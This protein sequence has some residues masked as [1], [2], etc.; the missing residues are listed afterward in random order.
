MKIT[1]LS[2]AYPYRG[3]I[4]HFTGL[5]YKELIKEHEVNVITF[6]RQYP[7][8]LFPGSTQKE[9]ENDKVQKIPTEQIV[10]SINPINW[11]TSGIRI[12]SIKPDL[13]IINFWLPFFG[14]SF[15]TISKIVK[16]NKKTKIVT[17][18]H[19]II[20]HERK[21]GDRLFTK[22]F[23]KS[24]DSF[25]LLAK[26]LE[27]DLKILKI[28]ARYK[29]LYH[30]VYS[31]FGEGIKK[32]EARELLKVEGEKVILFFG[33]IREYK[34]LDTLLEAFALIKDK[35]NLKLI[36]AGEFY[37]DEALYQELI[38]KLKIRENIYLFTRF[39]PS[40]EVRYYFSAADVVVLPYKNATQSGI[41][42][43]ANNF[44]KPVIATDVGGLGEV[45]FENKTGFLVVKENPGK[46]ADAILKYFNE[47]KEEEFANNI[48]QEEDKFSWNNFVK[49]L[50][51]AVK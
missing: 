12:N 26:K 23:F 4:A 42:Q 25:V 7:G 49:G 9:P 1:I 47:N 20:P 33:F 2:A 17:I 37:S 30:P 36:I 43:I 38:D 5:L 51:E 18:C 14:P 34:G 44:N 6:K 8:F 29:T 21:P 39:I 35:L 48:K 19:N 11:I 45:V 50:M 10:D 24:T 27:E 22:F 28:D 15:G 41:V 46:L 3:G 31:I 16:S 40:S 32:N 13:L